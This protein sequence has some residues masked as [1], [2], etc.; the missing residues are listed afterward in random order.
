MKIL[1]SHQKKSLNRGKAADNN[2]VTAEHIT[3][4]SDALANP[5][6]KLYDSMHMDK[7]SPVFKCRRKIPTPKKEKNSTDPNNNRVITITNILRKLQKVII[8][9]STCI[10]PKQHSLQYGFTKGLS[11][12]HAA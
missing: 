10:S 12:Q 8:K 3:F 6:K 1:E 2:G 5:L 11:P 7:Q 9:Q 4:V